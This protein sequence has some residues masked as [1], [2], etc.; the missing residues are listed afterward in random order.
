M[1]VNY[2]ERTENASTTDELAK[3]EFSHVDLA[4]NI[5]FDAF[6]I[7]IPTQ[8]FGLQN[9]N[10]SSSI[11]FYN[12]LKAYSCNTKAC[13]VSDVLKYAKLYD[14]TFETTV[15][16]RVQALA[17]CLNDAGEKTWLSI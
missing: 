14:N 16:P 2:F 17:I 7:E 12:P 9:D 1:I 10:S 15:Y 8:K 6:T 5:A 3:M 13:I 4:E 11:P